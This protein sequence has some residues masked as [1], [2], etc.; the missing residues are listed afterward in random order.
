[1]PSC[2]PNRGKKAAEHH[3]AT[4]P[5]M[6]LEQGLVYTSADWCSQSMH[7][8]WDAGGRLCSTD[9]RTQLLGSHIRKL[10]RCSICGVRGGK[11]TVAETTI[12]TATR[13]SS[14]C[15][16]LD[17][18]FHSMRAAK[19]GVIC[20]QRAVSNGRESNNECRGRVAH[21]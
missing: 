17:R 4:T 18:D 3:S 2:Y 5:G 11:D 13:S 21:H 16:T 1:M 9:K 14:F 8:G 12:H 15:S 19:S 6:V 7:A 10:L 20:V